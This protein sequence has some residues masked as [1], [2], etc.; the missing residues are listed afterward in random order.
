MYLRHF[1]WENASFSFLYILYQLG[2]FTLPIAENA[3]ETGFNNKENFLI[4]KPGFH[5]F[6]CGLIQAGLRQCDQDVVKNFFFPF[7][8]W[9]VSPNYCTCFILRQ[10]FPLKYKLLCQQLA[11][12]HSS[13]FISVRKEK[14]ISDT[15]YKRRSLSFPWRLR[16]YFWLGYTPIS[17]PICG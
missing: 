13:L 10:I 17:E 5:T 16:K 9:P 6:R 3:I 2:F 1:T 4:W 7:Y 14:S 15:S 11:Q 8:F 12:L